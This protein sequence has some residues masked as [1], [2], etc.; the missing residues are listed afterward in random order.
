MSAS[1]DYFTLDLGYDWLRTG[2]Y[3]VAPFVGYNYFRYKMNALGCTF[4]E[5]SPPESCGGPP[6]GVGLQEMDEW[7]SWRLGAVGE[8]MLTPQLRVTG[9]VAYLPFVR[10]AG[11]DN[12]IGRGRSPQ[13]GVG[14]GVQ[15]EGIAAYDVTEQISL[16]IG[17]RFWSMSVPSGLTNNLGRGDFIQERYAAENAALFAQGSYRFDAPLD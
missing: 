12:H 16:G 3:R 9:E 1:L 5:L 13:H 8:L 15:L 2:N 7:R 17:A 14:T 4:M 6:T 11:V 10:Y